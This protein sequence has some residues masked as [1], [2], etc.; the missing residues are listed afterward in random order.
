MSRPTS[1]GLDYAYR[2][3]IVDRYSST[4]TQKSRLKTLFFLNSFYLLSVL[5]L[6]VHAHAIDFSK[7][8]LDGVL[9]AVVVFSVGL[10]FE[11]YRN[12]KNESGALKTYVAL[13]SL[14][15]VSV[16][17]VAFMQYYFG[18]REWKHSN[19]DFRHHAFVHTFSIILCL[20]GVVVAARIISHL[21]AFKTKK[22]G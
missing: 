10:Y 11:Y 15:I 12:D 18:V 6:N 21:S 22:R 3:T 16:A 13:R 14:N 17:W 5:A 2:Q 1:D 19:G 4:A 7:F 20:L 9:V 8:L